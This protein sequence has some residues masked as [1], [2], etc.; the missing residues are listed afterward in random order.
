[1][2][3]PDL[4]QTPTPRP[5]RSELATPH[6]EEHGGQSNEG[7]EATDP[8]GHYDTQVMPDSSTH[9]PPGAT[10]PSEET[11]E[12]LDPRLLRRLFIAFLIIAAIAVLSIISF[13]RA[14]L[15]IPWYVFGLTFIVIVAAA[16]APL[17]E[18]EPAPADDNDDPAG[19]IGPRK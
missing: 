15:T 17:F 4:L 8:H 16:L 3:L 9:R 5:G 1:M 12:P 18:Q 10:S 13:P 2:L 6:Q 11:S 7:G 19:R 14:N